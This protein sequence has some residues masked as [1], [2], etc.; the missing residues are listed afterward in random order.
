MKMTSLDYLHLAREEQTVELASYV[1]NNQRARIIELENALSILKGY[2]YEPDR[3]HGQMCVIC[4][5]F[6]KTQDEVKHIPPCPL[7]YL[8][9]EGRIV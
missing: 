4:G 8:Y 5:G 2:L 6:G 1:I 7:P 9:N 3:E